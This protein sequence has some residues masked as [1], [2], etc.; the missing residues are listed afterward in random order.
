MAAR[1]KYSRQRRVSGTSKLWTSKY[2]R[3]RA[4]EARTKL[5]EMKDANAKATMERV[6][7]TYQRLAE[8]Q[9]SN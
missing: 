9:T 7:E 6:A 1:S 8:R 2:W 5:S 3:D 4:E